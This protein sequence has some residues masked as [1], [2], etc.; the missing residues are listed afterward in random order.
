MRRSLQISLLSSTVFCV[1][2]GAWADAI[3]VV[4]A[5]RGD[6]ALVLNGAVGDW[7]GVAPLVAV[8]DAAQVV[9][10]ASAWTG[11]S[12]ASFTF[13]LARDEQLLYVAAEVHDDQIVRTAAHRANEDAL[14]VTI[15]AGEGNRAPT[16]EL[17]IQPGVTGQFPGRVRLGAR[18]IAGAL[19]SDAPLAEGSGFTIEASIPLRALPAL[20]SN[21]AVLRARVAYQDADAAGRAAADTVIA[22]G[23]GDAQHPGELPLVAPAGVH[24]TDALIRSFADAYH[25]DLT[26]TFL[27]RPENVAGDAALERVIVMPRF[28]VA[29]GPG[30][31]GGQRYTI[32][33]HPARARGDVLESE[34]R[35]VTGD[36]RKDVILRLLVA[37]RNHA[38][39]LLYVYG[40]PEGGSHLRRI[41]AHELAYTEGSNGV[42]DRATFEPSGGGIRVTL[43]NATGY[44]ATRRPP[45]PE[46]GTLPPLA[47]WGPN[48]LAVYRWS[49]AT[50][51]FEPARTEPNGGN[52]VADTPSQ[53]MTEAPTSLD[54]VLRNFRRREHLPEDARPQ[55]TAAGNVAGDRVPETVQI[56]GRHLVVVG[57]N[58]MSGR[59]SYS[60]E[61]PVDND[62]DVLGLQL[63]DVTDDGHE[64]ALIRVRRTNQ[65]SVRG[66]QLDVQHEYLMVYSFDEGHRGRVL[67][68]EIARRAGGDSIT[69]VVRP[70]PHG[71][72]NSLTIEAGTSGGGWNAQTYPFH[73]QPM[74]GFEPLLVPW[75]P[76]RRVTYR[77]NGT[78]LV[79][80]P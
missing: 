38:R 33:E 56:Y 53:S 31:E 8:D 62:A 63:G 60:L 5:P 25:V 54:A 34:L 45:A 69:N 1:A 3:P 21:A 29:A 50:H 44:S 65:S 47:P 64:D 57:E 46:A 26:D 15:A 11:P 36:G 78:A 37:E 48:R 66:R 71:R 4:I 16:Y 14:I 32:I 58:F 74:T 72:N 73:D 42:T 7:R 10:G 67:A 79:A 59:S 6:H 76:A 77:W 13:A 19:V 43:N 12:D 80:A 40:A 2:A 28:I 55:F 52:V 24:G 70:P 22:S 30:L 49:D 27:D 18:P 35:D 20:A 51:S 23:P 41:F 17:V 61:L 39:E 9:R 68:V 75:G